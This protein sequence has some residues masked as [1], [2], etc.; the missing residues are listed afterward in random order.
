MDIQLYQNIEEG[1]FQLLVIKVL[2][3]LL[4]NKYNLLLGQLCRTSDVQ[5]HA[6]KLRERRLFVATTRLRWS[7][8]VSTALIRWSTAIISTVVLVVVFVICV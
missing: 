5:Q 7:V 4:C 6:T 1:I 8:I 2:S 3:K